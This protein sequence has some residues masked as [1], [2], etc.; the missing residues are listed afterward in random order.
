M[1][2]KWPIR[3]TTIVITCQLT[4]AMKIPLNKSNSL[5][6]VLGVDSKGC[7]KALRPAQGVLFGPDGMVAARWADGSPS[8]P[9]I[10]PDL[11]KDELAPESILVADESG[12]LYRFAPVERGGVKRHL[13]YESGAF[14]LEPVNSDALCFP[15]DDVKSNGKCD[16]LFAVFSSCNA[17]SGLLCLRKATR[18]DL[19][20]EENLE[21][22]DADANG[23]NGLVMTKEVDGVL[24]QVCVKPECGKSFTTCCKDGG[25]PLLKLRS[26]GLQFHP[27]GITNVATGSGATTHHAILPQYPTDACGDVYALF[28]STGNSF[29]G[30]SG[31]TTRI[32]G[33]IGSYYL[34]QSGYVGDAFATQAMAKVTSANTD[35]VITKAGTGTSGYTIALL[36]YYY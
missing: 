24:K 4:D 27:V 15:E 26:D 29:E 7:E 25:D 3:R 17:G 32:T 23:Y 19:F 31:A 10:L 11:D 30:P 5:Q 8:N 35:I 13:V 20:P 33:V 18:E 36:G 34:F 2:L 9:I 12:R 28:Q 16:S 22:E 6:F 1:H 14:S 21:C